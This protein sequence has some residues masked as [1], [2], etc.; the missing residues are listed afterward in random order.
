MRLSSSR[1]LLGVLSA[2][3]LGLSASLSCVHAEDVLAV[4]AA[5]N[6]IRFDASSPGTLISTTPITGLQTG[7]KIVAI[8]FRTYNGQ[9]YGIAISAT[10][11]GGV[12]PPVPNFTGRLY[13]INPVTGVASLVGLQTPPQTPLPNFSTTLTGSH[14]SFTYVPTFASDLFRVDNENGQNLRVSPVNGSLVAT[15]SS[16]TYNDANATSSPHVVAL[17]QS[18][19][20]VNAPGST[21]YAIDSTLGI[22]TTHTGNSGF[23][24]Q[25]GKLGV[26]IG[27]NAG[28][29]I[30][31]FSGTA[32]AALQPAGATTSSFFNIDLAT[33]SATLL[34]AIGSPDLVVSIA[35]PPPPVVFAFG[36]TQDVVNTV[37]KVNPGLAKFNLASPAVLVAQSPI[38]GLPNG[39]FLVALDF[40]PSNGSLYGLTSNGNDF[41]LYTIDTVTGAATAVGSTIKLPNPSGGLRYS[42]NFDPVRDVLRIH[43]S[44]GGLNARVDPKTATLINLDP[45][46]AYVT[47][48]PNFGRTPVLAGSAYTNKNNGVAST[49]L[50][51]LDQTGS[52]TLITTQSPQDAGTLNTQMFTNAGVPTQ[53]SIALTNVNSFQVAPDGRGFILNA[54][55]TLQ[56]VNLVNGAT[57]SF[58]TVPGLTSPATT[59]RLLA[60]PSQTAGTTGSGAG[61][62]QFSAAS[63]QVIETN[64]AQITVSRS[65]GSTGIATIDYAIGTGGTAVTPGGLATPVTD[66]SPLTGTL[67]F[68]DGETSRTINV[69]TFDDKTLDLFKTVNLTLKNPVGALLGAQSTATLIISDKD[70]IDGDGFTNE[71]ETL[72]GSDPAS[73][74]STPFSGA[75]AGTAQ[76]LT[77]TKFSAKLNFAKSGGDSVS[78]SGT[79][80]FTGTVLG[81]PV[82]V[83]VGGVGGVLGR[84]TL[85]KSG[86]D[87]KGTCRPAGGTNSFKL[88]TSKSGGVAKYTVTMSK[89]TFAT[90]LANSGLT[91]IDASK[92]AATITLD[93]YLNNV[94]Y[95]AT[96]S[97]TYSAKKGKSGNAQLAKV[98]K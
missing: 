64:V 91:S 30:S 82:L 75:P 32:F 35:V 61:A 24:N 4:T 11:P 69:P 27:D 43:A 79:V 96:K 88:Q 34:A 58:G 13:Q 29:T 77:V 41:G 76:T 86:S 53:S 71:L 51:F 1:S 22:L 56:L 89:N 83:D 67:T 9:L 73:A 36:A 42:M 59:V 62:I 12:P 50:L 95:E 10:P 60:I 94:K 66:Y 65:G 92:Q 87:K 5:N 48:D 40:R 52:K 57:Q 8:D 20:F 93:L 19:K 98:K 90:F 63:Y 70:D 78:L 37:T 6:L 21:L 54:G 68:L 85:D 16:L 15:D 84:F 46:P 23:L 25:I 31:P 97:L 49:T 39:S 81:K 47:G 3:V 80:P 28:F 14:Y 26:A 2:L 45:A 33:G 72:F 74:S 17:T 18:N 38:T 44:N 7:E 55:T